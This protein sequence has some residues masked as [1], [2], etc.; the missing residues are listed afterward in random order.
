MATVAWLS[1]VEPQPI[2]MPTPSPVT[3]EVTC[4]M[5]VQAR[6]VTRNWGRTPRKLCCSIATSTSVRIPGSSDSSR[7]PE[8]RAYDVGRI[9]DGETV[10]FHELGLR[11]VRELLRLGAGAR[12]VEKLPIDVHGPDL[13]RRPDTTSQLHREMSRAASVVEDRLPLA[14]LGW[15]DERLQRIAPPEH[16]LVRLEPFGLHLDPVVLIVGLRF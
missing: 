7:H 10:A 6:P 8:A 1:R 15:C 2:R 13:A 3:S 5:G 16:L 4:R 14:D 12:A 11:P 9:G